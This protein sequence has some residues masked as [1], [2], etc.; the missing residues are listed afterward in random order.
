MPQPFQQSSIS[1]YFPKG[2]VQSQNKKS[3]IK[4]GTLIDLTHDED[5]MLSDED[6]SRPAK[7]QR[8]LEVVKQ[9][10]PATEVTS[11]P[12]TRVRVPIQS[13]DSCVAESVTDAKLY[14]GMTIERA[15]EMWAMGSASQLNKVEPAAEGLQSNTGARSTRQQAFVDKLS[16]TV[17]QRRNFQPD[18]RSSPLPSADDGGEDADLSRDDCNDNILLSED[19]RNIKTKT[20]KALPK[21]SLG[22]RK[23]K[24]I[25]PSG[26]AYTPLE[27]QVCACHAHWKTSL[28]FISRFWPLKSNTQ[29]FCSWWKLDTSIGA[30]SEVF[31]V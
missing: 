2:S 7:R 8:T 21:A 14:P 30:I 12:G 26:L 10:V 28:T 17:T 23:S 3:I 9:P 22:S 13:G 6:G 18:P 4:P 16:E 31:D 25:G 19:D 1:H 5:T 27:K 29:M 15:R 11:G 20:K 24:D